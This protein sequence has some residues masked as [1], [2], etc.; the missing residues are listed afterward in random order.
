[1]R[2]IVGLCLGLILLAG[3]MAGCGGNGTTL[4]RVKGL[5]PEKVVSTFYERAKSQELEEAALYI[6]PTSLTAISGVGGFLKN[7]LGLSDVLSSNLLMAKPI[8]EQGGFAVVLATLQDGLNSTRITVK[9]VGL[10]KIDGEWYIV[11]TNTAY[12]DAKYKALV[13]LLENIL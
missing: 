7:D 8:A 4:H 13:S 1:V 11:D 10:E 9:A 6:A 12:R 2:K 3:I 5:A